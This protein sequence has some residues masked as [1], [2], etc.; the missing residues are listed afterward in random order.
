MESVLGV[1]ES[2]IG[3]VWTLDL[4]MSSKKL[5]YKNDN[6]QKIVGDCLVKRTIKPGIR[7]TAR[8][9]YIFE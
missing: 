2:S 6:K 4:W 7:V 8:L 3:A 5:Q 9:R 1:H